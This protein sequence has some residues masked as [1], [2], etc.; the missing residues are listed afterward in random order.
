MQLF[1]S[2]ERSWELG[3][4]SWELAAG[5]LL[6][7][8]CFN[9]IQPRRFEGGEQPEED[10][11]ARGESDSDS[12]RPP[13]QRH[14]EP[15]ECMH[16]QADAAAERDPEQAAEGREEHGLDEE[17]P[18]DIAAA[19]AESLAHPNLARPTAHRH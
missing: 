3:A 8:Q 16:R 13:R 9:R 4:G 7:S 5:S 6:V 2:A 10:A 15:C 17:L 12:E 14:G 18:E 1:C 11:D 19:R